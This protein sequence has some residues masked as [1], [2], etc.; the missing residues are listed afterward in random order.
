MLVDNTTPLLIPLFA[1][2]LNVKRASFLRVLFVF[3]VFIFILPAMP[4]LTNALYAPA[5]DS[6]LIKQFCESSQNWLNVNEIC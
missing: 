5:I 4:T 1:H 6:L 2:K 3:C